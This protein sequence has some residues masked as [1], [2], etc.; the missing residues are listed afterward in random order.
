MESE[1][2]EKME[3]IFILIFVRGAN[4][5]REAGADGYIVEILRH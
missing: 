3:I 4:R 5:K 1:I 2:K